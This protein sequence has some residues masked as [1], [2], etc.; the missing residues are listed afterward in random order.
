MTTLHRTP[1]PRLLVATLNPGKRREL[2]RLLADLPTALVGPADLGLDLDVAETGDTFAANAALK[3]HAFAAAAGMPALADDSGIEV[4]ALGGFPGV[5]SAR[6]APGSD[7][8]R[9]AA[10]LARLADVP[11][12]DRT[13]RFR[14]VVVLAWPDGTVLDA[15]GVVEGRI[16]ERAVGTGGFGYDPVFLVEDGGYDGRRTM[17]ELSAE[18]KDR[19]SHRGRAVRR[20]SAALRAAWRVG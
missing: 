15:E 11:L 17:A 7:A 6:W 4:D 8:D 12:P 3:A 5:R 13:A 1:P 14:A 10:L 9:V 18:A 16:A 20:L 19:L 2:R